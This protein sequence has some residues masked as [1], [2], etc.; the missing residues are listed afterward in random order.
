MEEEIKT[1][2]GTGINKEL[3]SLI[4]LGTPEFALPALQK[5]VEADAPILQ[6][7]TQPDRPKGRGKKVAPSP[8]KILAE[9]LGLPLYQPG[10]LRE[11]EVIEHIR[12]FEAQCLVVVAYGQ[13]IPDEL[14]KA[15]PLG[16]LNIHPSLLPRHRGAAPLQRT[17]LA[18]DTVTGVSIMLLNEG[19]DTG[20]ILRQQSIPI[21]EEDNFGTLHDKLAELGGELLCE[22]LKEWKA[23]LL[24]PSPQEEAQAT[25]APP[26]QKEE[27]RLQWNFPA[28]QVFNTIRAFDPWPGAYSIYE[29]KRLKC[30]R[31]SL[32]SWKTEGRAGEILGATEE[33]L[34]VLAGDGQA[35]SIGELQLEGHRRLDAPTFFRGHSVS[36]G[37]CLE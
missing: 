25:Y 33:G 2:T 10:R 5:L 18:G 20:P 16:A 8:V 11:P 37:F 17:L 24:T 21:R 12:S 4:F 22:T 28:R 30:Y 27:T 13:L 23:G 9:Q 19:M 29:G 3:P 15:H 31:A 32:L 7:I 35:V 34:V 14:L 26:I 36:R 6:V 1:G